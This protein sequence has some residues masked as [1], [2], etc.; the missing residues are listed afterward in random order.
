MTTYINPSLVTSKSRQLVTNRILTAYNFGYNCINRPYRQSGVANNEPRHY[1]GMERAAKVRHF[2]FK[3]EELSNLDLTLNTATM[4]KFLDVVNFHYKNKQK[5]MWAINAAGPGN[6]I[7]GEAYSSTAHMTRVATTLPLVYQA[8]N[9]Q[10]TPPEAVSS[11]NEPNGSFPSA[12]RQAELARIVYQVTKIYSPSTIVGSPEYQGGTG[13]VFFPFLS[14]SAVG[15]A[16]NGNTGTG[17]LGEQW[18]DEI[19]IHPY[20]TLDTMA[21]ARTN[22]HKFCFDVVASSRGT[23]R[24]A[25]LQ[26]IAAGGYWKG[27]PFPRI[28]AT[29]YNI[30]GSTITSAE[31]SVRYQGFTEAEKESAI[32]YT[33]AL[34]LT[35][36]DDIYPYGPDHYDG[37]GAESGTPTSLVTVAAGTGGRALIDVPGAQKIFTGDDVV[38]TGAVGAPWINGIF[39]AVNPNGGNTQVELTGSVFASGYVPSSAQ[40]AWRRYGLGGWGVY[41]DKWMTKFMSAPFSSGIIIESDGTRR[42]WYQIGS[43][44]PIEAAAPSLFV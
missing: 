3:L 2:Q 11:S 31:T 12:A 19:F 26:R 42:F 34:G 21:L 41:Y 23:I 22:D 18:F 33:M 39:K 14:A 36:A 37:F 9:T 35:V 44:A 7:H 28:R 43:N 1:V 5:P 38:I 10:K 17:T 20:G 8:L 30:S 40:I 32:G 29:E 13:N 6:N 4:T 16:V 15:V 24:Q 27:K 25:F